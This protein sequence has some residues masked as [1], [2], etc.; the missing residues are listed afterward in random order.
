MYYAR[1]YT[2]YMQSPLHGVHS[3]LFP[4]DSR[5]EIAIPPFQKRNI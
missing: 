5:Y 2:P 3:Q 1:H 4:T